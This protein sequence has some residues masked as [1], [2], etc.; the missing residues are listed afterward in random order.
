MNARDFAYWRKSC[1]FVTANPPPYLPR[2]DAEPPPAIL[3]ETYTVRSPLVYIWHRERCINCPT[4][5]K[6]FI[7]LLNKY[8]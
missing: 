2:G 6:A 5:E 4:G 8:L 1:I 3:P 7:G